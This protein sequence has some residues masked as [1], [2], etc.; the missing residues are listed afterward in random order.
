MHSVKEAETTILNLISPLDKSQDSESIPLEAAAGKI[1]AQTLISP[2]DFPHWNNSAMDG[3]AVRYGDV[4]ECP[5]SLEIIEEIPA[6]F[7]PKKTVQTGQAARIFTGA[8]LPQGADTIVIQE[9]TERQGDRVVILQPPQP[10]DFVRHR[11]S[12]HQA[13]TPL[14]QGGIQ[15]GAPEVAILAAAQQTQLQVYRRPTVALLST[16]DELVAPDRALEPGQIVDSNQYALAAFVA[17]NGGIPVPLG[18]VEDCRDRLKA[19][20]ERAVATCDVVLSTGG[21]SVGDRD[22]IQTLLDELG[23]EMHIRSVAV[24]PGKPLTVATFNRNERICP[25]FGLPGNPVSALVSCWRFVQPALQKLSGLAPPWGCEFV[26]ARSRSRLKG[27]K[28][29]ETYLWGQLHNIEGT[30][31]FSLA[32]GSHSSGNLIN[33]AQTNGLA[34]VPPGETHLDA[35]SD[36]RV[37]FVN[38]KL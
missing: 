21:V 10:Q 14:L 26:K 35:G 18:I 7:N 8:I 33:L 30:Y 22:Y 28:T 2:L 19:A 37:L 9:N 25:Y 3:Y 6:G 36:L 24:K 5:T 15:L 34:V 31:E 16:G 11:G 4:Q 38:R 32:G 17:Q 27:T 13:G 23:A 12:F 1:L 29:R 20:I